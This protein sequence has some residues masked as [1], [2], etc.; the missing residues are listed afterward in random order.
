MLLIVTNYSKLIHDAESRI[1][2]YLHDICV[3]KLY[4]HL[5]S[6]ICKEVETVLQYLFFSE[7]IVTWFLLLEIGKCDVICGV[8]GMIIA[9][10][11][12]NLSQ[13]TDDC[14][15]GLFCHVVR[16]LVLLA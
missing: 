4:G 12:G 9:F 6:F 5:G 2:L 8:P 1:P 13:W 14:Q 10:K 3:Q 7:A 16:C 15:Q 11:L